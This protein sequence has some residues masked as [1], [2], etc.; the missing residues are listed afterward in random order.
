MNKILIIG[1]NSFAGSDFIDFILN[2]KIKIF[3]VS[4]SNQINKE[5]LRYKN[6]KNIKN[7][8]FYKIDLNKKR[9]LDKLIRIIKKQ[10]IQYI[11]NFA[12]QGMVAESWINPE[13]WYL[14]NIVS[15]AIL[16]KK[17]SKIKINKYLNFSTPE[18][19]GN[20]SSLKR[21]G[22][23]FS[24]TTPYAIS[25]TAQDLNLLAY[26]KTYNFPV[27]FTRAANIYGP[28]QQNYRIIPKIIIS[29][30]M[31]KKIPIHGKGNTL[32]SFVY[33]PDVSKALYKIL[34]DKKN[35]GETFHISSKKFISILNLVKLIKKIMKV[36]SHITYHTKERDGK[37][38]KYTLN[39]NKVRKRYSWLE[40]TSLDDGIIDTINWVK[41]NINY[42]KKAPLKYIHKK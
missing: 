13:D 40:K 20:T 15:N 9:D 14:T 8:K 1:S 31:K 27:V 24:P 21:E 33:M 7:L 34:L 6:N 3:A 41:N 11:V 30:L 5:N 28:Y 4:R 16:I 19:Y 22:N 10:K 37:D 25:R 42:F 18:V 38:L 32:R 26:Y 29:I 23:L 35:I 2:K 17:L 12:A 39:S 36:N